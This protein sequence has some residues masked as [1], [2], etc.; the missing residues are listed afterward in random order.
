MKNEI[1]LPPRVEIGFYQAPR[2]VFSSGVATSTNRILL[3][4]A[5]VL[6]ASCGGGSDTSSDQSGQKSGS[7]AWLSGSNASGL[8]CP[9][10]GQAASARFANIGGL[11][12][13]G[14]D[15]LLVSEWTD[16]PC[17]DVYAPIGKSS[18]RVVQTRNGAVSTL[19]SIPRYK[20]PSPANKISGPWSGIAVDSSG[21][22]SV[23]AE[24]QG[25]VLTG[26]DI[27]EG[28]VY[29]ISA[30]GSLL[31][32]Q[33]LDLGALDSIVLGIDRTY[34][35]G[36]ADGGGVIYIYDGIQSTQL[37]IQDSSTGHRIYLQAMAIGTGNDV[38]LASKT[39][40]YKMDTTTTA[41]LVAGNVSSA[42][43]NDGSGGEARFSAI[44]PQ[45]MAIDKDGSIYVVDGG[46]LIRKMTS[47][48]VVTTV[49]GQPGENA[50]IQ[51]GSLP[52]KLADAR[53]I[54]VDQD[55]RL[56]VQ[57]RSG[58]LVIDQK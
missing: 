2:G 44:T 58:I 22:I 55:A 45:G 17:D 42:G 53:A 50:S 29:R 48:G 47:Q 7:I 21:A 49:A 37:E 3:A 52:G 30:T 32:L 57:A 16:Q 8:E 46:N 28:G 56:Y 5:S 35:F 43:S 26:S 41:K 33:P 14:N 20:S 54:A 4:L 10:D 23:V 6:L 36:A 27:N 18:V 31:S 11:A 40:I 51:T 38:Y 39:A 12:V 24:G 19:F 9:I 25:F 13:D 1:S 15:K 34:L